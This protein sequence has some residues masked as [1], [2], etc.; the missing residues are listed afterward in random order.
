[1]KNI[2]LP[3]KY[4]DMDDNSELNPANCTLELSEYLIHFSCCDQNRLQ[5]VGMKQLL[6][7]ES[8][9]DQRRDTFKNVI[10]CPWF[11]KKS[12]IKGSQF[13]LREDE[14][15][16]VIRLIDQDINALY[17]HCSETI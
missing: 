11:D 3:E 5:L 7:S 16:Q 15:M 13:A 1:M 2:R 4:N 8:A 10:L 14:D 12:I 17:Q 6:V 9:M